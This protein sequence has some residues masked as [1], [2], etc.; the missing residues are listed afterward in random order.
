MRKTITEDVWIEFTC[1][2]CKGINN[3]LFDII[4]GSNKEGVITKQEVKCIHNACVNTIDIN[5][6]IPPYS[7]Y[8]DM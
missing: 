8:R 1:I 6:E 3:V 2:Q 7:I 4:K 5:G